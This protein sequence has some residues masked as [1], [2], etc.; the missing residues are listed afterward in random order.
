[1]ENPIYDL[2]I[3]NVPGAQDVSISPPVEQTTQAVQTESQENATRDLTP[4]LTPLIDPGTEGV[5]K[6]KNE[7]SHQVVKCAFSKS[8]DDSSSP[9]DSVTDEMTSNKVTTS[10]AAE[11]NENRSESSQSKPEPSYQY[12]GNQ[13]SRLNPEGR[14]QY[15]RN[16]LLKL[17]YEP[18]SMI[19]PVNLPAL[20]DIILNESTPGQTNDMVFRHKSMELDRSS[21]ASPPDFLPWFV[22]F[23]PNGDRYTQGDYHQRRRPTQQTGGNMGNNQEELRK[24]QMFQKRQFNYRGKETVTDVKGQPRKR[25]RGNRLSR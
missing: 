4:I 21:V 22:K 15:D 25:Q 6:P 10:T 11:V 7:T 23:V 24:H 2:V 17:Q 19:R 1:M 3:G 18:T 12:S 13:C 20:P 5:A 14:K 8:I 16:F 9:D